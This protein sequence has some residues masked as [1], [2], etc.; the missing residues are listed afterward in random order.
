[1]IHK[2]FATLQAAIIFEQEGFLLVCELRGIVGFDS[3]IGSGRGSGARIGFARGTSENV[4]LRLGSGIGTRD[5]ARSSS[6]LFES[7]DGL[8]TLK[9]LF[10]VE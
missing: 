1:V 2:R 10:I 8:E 9:T 4:I 6:T 5:G 7:L 3:G